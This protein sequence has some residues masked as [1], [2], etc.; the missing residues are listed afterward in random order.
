MSTLPL[1]LPPLVLLPSNISHLHPL[2][3]MS[4]VCSLVALAAMASSGP[5]CLAL[6]MYC[7]LEQ[8]LL[9]FLFENRDC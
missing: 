8:K 1:S 7:N 2:T 3:V 4:V 5:C 9:I 6:D